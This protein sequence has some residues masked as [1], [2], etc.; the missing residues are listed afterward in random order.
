MLIFVCICLTLNIFGN[1][2]T[3][4]LLCLL[5]LLLV[6]LL[7][8]ALHFFRYLIHVRSGEFYIEQGY[9]R[10][11]WTHVVL[12]YYGH[13][14]GQETELYLDGILTNHRTW[15]YSWSKTPEDG[16]IV[17]GRI[18]PTQDK[19]YGSVK[20]DELTMFNSVLSADDILDLSRHA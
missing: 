17:V 12:N 5:H 11:G 19:D 10:V 15:K 4:R 13:E 7:N 6:L 2:S 14:D 9:H 8:M 16:R 20:V 1:A 18:D 3:L